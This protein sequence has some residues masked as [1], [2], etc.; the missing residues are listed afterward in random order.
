[1]S[2]RNPGLHGRGY[3]RAQDGRVDASQGTVQ[4]QEFV[5]L[6]FYCTDHPGKRIVRIGV[7]LPN[8]D[9]ELWSSPYPVAHQELNGQQYI[10]VQCPVGECGR[11][12]LRLLRE[13]RESIRALAETENRRARRIEF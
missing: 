7:N 10:Y 12:H 5:A 2:R 3:K 11:P 9:G 6:D 8:L 13:V 4:G 1:M